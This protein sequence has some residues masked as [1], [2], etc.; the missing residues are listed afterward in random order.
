ML[1]LR[2]LPLRGVLDPGLMGIRATA[3]SHPAHRGCPSFSA[4]DTGGHSSL[5][6]PASVRPFGT[7][8]SQGVGAAQECGMGLEGAT[9]APVGDNSVCGGHANG[10]GGDW[11]HQPYKP[12]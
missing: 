5:Q 11:W 9:T 6:A 1:L 8:T 10:G 2:C 7:N 3:E 12:L 4:K